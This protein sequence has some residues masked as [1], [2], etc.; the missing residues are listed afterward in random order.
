VFTGLIADV[1]SVQSLQAGDDGALIAI[2]TTLASQVA[3]GDSVAVS[4]VCLTATEAA[5]AGFTAQAMNETL[6][7]TT[8]AGLAPASR[9][10]LELA[11]RAGDR[12]G[13]HVVQ[14]HIDGLARLKAG[15]GDGFSRVLTFMAPPELSHYIVEKGSVALDGVSLTVSALDGDDFAVSLIPET[16]ARTTLGELQVGE[17][18]NLEVDL[19]A[20][21]V[22]RMIG[23]RT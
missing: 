6:R 21:Y 15:E 18:V 9:V 22:E 4:G 14:G 17:Q 3:P 7:R 8:L 2:S 5:S 20:K 19:M 1:G 12:L 13:G 16:L 11:L 23:A 10:N